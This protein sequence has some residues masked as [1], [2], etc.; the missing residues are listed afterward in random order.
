MIFIVILLIVF[1]ST[2][3]HF[4]KD[5]ADY[6]INTQNIGIIAISFIMSLALFTE[7]CAQILD[8]IN[9]L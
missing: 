2:M 1:V 3:L 7:L 6:G 4:I 8:K 9:F 5:L